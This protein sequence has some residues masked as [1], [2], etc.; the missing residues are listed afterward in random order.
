MAARQQL[1]RDTQNVTSKKSN[2]FFGGALILLWVVIYLA[3]QL[4]WI[5]S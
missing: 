2:R 5:K 3:I 1:S 4:H